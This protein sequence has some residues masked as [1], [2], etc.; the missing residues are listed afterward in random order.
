MVLR[1][2]IK[3][4]KCGRSPASCRRASR[5]IPVPPGVKPATGRSSLTEAHCPV[6]LVHGAG[7]DPSQGRG[8]PAVRQVGQVSIIRSIGPDRSRRRLPLPGDGQDLL[9]AVP[10]SS[11][12]ELTQPRRRRSVRPNRL[13][14][15]S[16][17]CTT[18]T[19][20]VR[21]STEGT[22]RGAATRPPLL[23]LDSIGANCKAPPVPGPL[24]ARERELAQLREFLAGASARRTLVL[25]GAPG[26]G[27]TALWEAGIDAAREL[28]HARRAWRGRAAPRRATRSRA[29]IDLFDGVDL[30]GLP[31]PQ[32][33]ALEVALLRAA[34]AGRA[35]AA[36]GDRARACSTSCAGWRARCWWRSTTCSG[37]TRPP[38]RRW[39]SPRRGSRSE[40]VA[41]LLARRPGRRP[42]LE[43][44]LGGRERLEVGP[45]DLDATRR[46]LSERLGLSVP[47]PL[48]RRIADTTLG[49][50]LFALEVGPRAGRARPA[51][52]RR[53]APAAGRG[54]GH[55]RHPRGVAAG[56]AAPDPARGRAERRPARGRARGGRRRRR[57]RGRRRRRAAARRG[58]PR[59]RLASA[60]RRRGPQARAAARAA[61]APPRARAAWSPATSCGRATWRCAARDPDA[62]LA[63]TVA[64]GRRRRG[65]ARRRGRGRRARRA[66]AAADAGRPARAHRAP[67]RARP[68][69]RDG[70]RAAAGERPA[71]RPSSRRCRRAARASAPGC[72]WRTGARSR[73]Y[74]ERRA[75]FEHALAEAGADP[76]LRAHALA[77]MA[78]STAAEGVE[79]IGEV[80]AWAQEALRGAAPGR[81]SSGSP[82]ARWAG[83]TRLRGRP[84]DDVCERFLAASP[85]AVQLIDSPE[86]VAALRL[87]WRGDLERARDDAD[88]LPRARRRARRGGLVR[89][90]APEPVR[91]RAAGGRLGR[92]CRGCSTSGPS[93]PTRSC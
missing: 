11:E 84:I 64:R 69:A 15:L 37:S 42:P 35:A 88:A 76:A 48:M 47:R 45:L 82:C 51:G 9:T 77:S 28:G 19:V 74:H 73:T 57:G 4:P 31:G 40:R 53:G 91:A 89:V 66:G 2:G 22:E 52:D 56:R 93:P 13:L 43:R 39:P 17:R 8:D 33:S 60:A 7:P 67:A 62:G 49:N 79:R 65:R 72:C 61:R 29:L 70:R 71:R 5:S 25:T 10:S 80:E 24:V 36:P 14:R 30:A 41:F 21:G 86:P 32:R 26:I 85:G 12:G 63:D 23:I 6:V 59:P 58:G 20:L 18:G 75:H 46:L 34:P 90:D 1:C 87:V 55:A 54:R 81:G 16:R 44:V 83:R 27:K 50:P 38:P 3:C 78:L 68:P 92:R